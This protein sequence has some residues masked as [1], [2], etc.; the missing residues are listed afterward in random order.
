MRLNQHVTAIRP[1]TIGIFGG[2][3][4]GRVWVHNND[5]DTWHNSVGG[6]FWIGSLNAFSV[7]AGYF[8]SKE[9]AIIQV[10]LGYG[11]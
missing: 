7:N 10:G 4:Y 1:I 2:F 5:A 8:L 11:F 6:G 9:D 3:D